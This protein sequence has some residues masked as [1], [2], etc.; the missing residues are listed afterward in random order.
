MILVLV[1]DPL[2]IVLVIAGIS[3]LETKKE[4][5]VIDEQKIYNSARAQ[6]IVD[7][8]PH[9]DIEEIEEVIVEP[10]EDVIPAP[11]VKS[12]RAV[13]ETNDQ[14]ELNKSSRNIKKETKKKALLYV[15]Q[16]SN[17]LIEGGR[18]ITSIS[19]VVAADETG[20]LGQL[21]EEADQDTLN[22]VKSIIANKIQE[23][24]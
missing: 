6:R 4:E 18:N 14:V 1:F 21:L 12:E 9:D 24:K 10:M 22:D 19:D 11:I 5:D 16:I 3:I 13:R 7:N 17:R 8:V 2:A 23:S 20:T 15:E